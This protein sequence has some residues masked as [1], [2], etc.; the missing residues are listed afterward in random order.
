MLRL[1]WRFLH[2][3]ALDDFPSLEQFEAVGPV[4]EDPAGERA[5]AMLADGL[6]DRS[7]GFFS[8]RIVKDQ[9]IGIG[10][11]PCRGIPGGSH[12][13]IVFPVPL[14]VVFQVRVFEERELQIRLVGELRHAETDLPERRIPVMTFMTCLSMKASSW[15]KYNF[16][17]IIF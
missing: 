1:L 4:G 14:P 5:V 11:R 15:S 17:S 7:E 13:L 3:V 9:R 12:P 2:D 6:F 16:R 10:S 8:R